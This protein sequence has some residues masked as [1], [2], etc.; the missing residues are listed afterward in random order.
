MTLGHNVLPVVFDELC[1]LLG[2]VFGVVAC[3]ASV[4]LGWLTGAAEVFDK[5][6][7]RLVLRLVFAE[8]KSRT[9]SAEAKRQAA[10]CGEHHRVLPLLRRAVTPEVPPQGEAFKGVVVARLDVVGAVDRLDYILGDFL[11]REQVDDGRLILAESIAEQEYLKLGVGYVTERAAVCDRHRRVGLNVYRERF[12]Q[13]RQLLPQR[14]PKS[15]SALRPPERRSPSRVLMRLFSPAATPL[16][17][18]FS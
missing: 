5:R 8:A 10:D 17:P 4:D 1:P 2:G 16:L 3:A 13:S 18:L 6:L 15:S 12:H 14:S 9:D 7:T 11:A